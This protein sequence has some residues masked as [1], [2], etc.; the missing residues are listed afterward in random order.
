[1]ILIDLENEKSL[2]GSETKNRKASKE[3]TNSNLS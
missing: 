3:P 2:Y 1:M